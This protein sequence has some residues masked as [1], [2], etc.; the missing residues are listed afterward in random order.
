MRSVT[1]PDVDPAGRY[2][3]SAAAAAIGVHRNTLAKYCKQGLIQQHVSDTGRRFYF[4][5]D[6]EKLW[7]R[8]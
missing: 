4:G 1:K 5:R 7:R 6:L 3:T 2:G 8:L